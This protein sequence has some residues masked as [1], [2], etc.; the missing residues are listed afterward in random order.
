MTILSE[1]IAHALSVKLRVTVKG[2]RKSNSLFDANFTGILT[3]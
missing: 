2:I 3:V 1:L